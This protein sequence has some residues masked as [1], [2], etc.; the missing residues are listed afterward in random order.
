MFDNL[1]LNTDSYK[2]SHA[3]QY[4]PNTTRVF[5]YIESRGG[6]FDRTV[7]FGLQGFLKQYLSRPVTAEQVDE[8]AEFWAAHGEPF[9]REGWD[10]IVQKHGGVL[11]VKIRAVAEGTVVPTHNVLVTVENTD[12]QCFWLTSFLE[13]A[14]LRAVW[15][16]T[17]VAT[18]SWHAQIGRAHV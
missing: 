2:A 18:V 15:Y 8:A 12:P 13:T 9:Y 6:K 7:F 10:Y 4:P 14:I 16:P 3:F 1:L 11:P 17:T 5:S